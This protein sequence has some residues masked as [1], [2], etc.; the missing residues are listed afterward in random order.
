MSSSDIASR[1]NSGSMSSRRSG[2]KSPAP[3]VARSQP[4][5]LTHIVA[6]SRPAWSSERPLAEV[7]PPP[8]FATER[9]APSRCEAC[10]TSPSVP[11]GPPSSGLDQRSGAGVIIGVMMF[12]C[13]PFA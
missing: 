6:T 5:P 2:V 13:G 7:L 11:V 1:S 9:S 10:R 8:K 12:T 3:M 4:E